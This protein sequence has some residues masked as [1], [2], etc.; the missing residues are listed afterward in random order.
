MVAIIATTVSMV[1]PEEDEFTRWENLTTRKVVVHETQGFTSE[2]GVIYKDV[3]FCGK[4]DGT[5]VKRISS[6]KEALNWIK[7]ID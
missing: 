1:G 7:T 3:Y 6:L 5:L 4:M 2:F